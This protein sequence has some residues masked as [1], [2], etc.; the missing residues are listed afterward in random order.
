MSKIIWIFLNFFSLKNIS[1]EEGLLLS[2]LENFN[3]WTTL[4]FKIAPNFWWSVWTSLKV[5]S[6]NHFHFTDFFLLKSTPCWLTST[7]LR[8][9]GHT[10]I[11]LCFVMLA[12]SSSGTWASERILRFPLQNLAPAQLCSS[13]HYKLWP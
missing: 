3:F 13:K 8:Q 10:R 6:N 11:Y 2:L 4:F 1:L 5:K 12:E 9:W 7:K